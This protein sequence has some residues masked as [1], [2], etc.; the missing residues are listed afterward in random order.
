MDKKKLLSLAGP[1]LLCWGVFAPVL[2]VP[3]LGGLNYFFCG[4]GD[5]ALLLVLALLSILLAI[6]GKYSALWYTGAASAGVV[7]FT[8]INLRLGL[9]DLGLLTSQNYQLSWGWVVLIAGIGTVLASAAFKAAKDQQ[10][11]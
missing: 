9:S 1:L 4:K 5:G 3:A 2:K 10:Q 11:A 6:K 7:T 8:F